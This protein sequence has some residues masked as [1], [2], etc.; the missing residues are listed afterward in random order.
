MSKIIMEIYKA[1]TENIKPYEDNAK[2]HQE[3]QVQKIA[4]S[5]DEFGFNQPIVLDKDNEIIAGHGRYQAAKKLG[6]KEVP[7]LN[8]EDL[9]DEQ[10]K[11]YRLA[12][13]KLNESEWDMDLVIDELVELEQEDFDI[14]LTGFDRDIILDDI[15]EEEE[16]IPEIDEESE[17]EAELGDV[18]KLGEHRLVCGDATKEEDVE[19]LMDGDKVDFMFNDIPFDM[20]LDELEKIYYTHK[21]ITKG[22]YF[23]MGSDK[24]V[25]KYTF[26]NLDKFHHFFIHDRKIP[27][28]ISNKSVMHRHNLVSSFSFGDKPQDKFKNMKDGF[29]TIIEASRG[30]NDKDRKDGIKM[31]KSI[32]LME[33]F[34]K[35]YTKE[36]DKVLDLFG[37]GGTTLITSEK[38]N[39]KCY[40]MELDPKYVD[41][42]IKRWE[43]FTGQKVEKL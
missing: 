37:G 34:L 19:K 14:E 12:D 21:Y 41:V 2:K 42:I 25:T 39:R 1:K 4:E 28:L 13:N 32:K 27:M 17:P 15:E 5:I 24:Q 23:F 22:Y 8:K 26:D 11:A 20:N 9:T 3:E 31:S 33:T 29:T 43:N 6:L 36:A 38:L 30:Y 16:E 40:M 18:Y 7:V 35:H 10:V